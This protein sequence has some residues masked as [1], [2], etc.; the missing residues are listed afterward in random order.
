V[1][2]QLPDDVPALDELLSDRRLLAPIVTHR[3]RGAEPTRRAMRVTIAEAKARVRDRSR[4]MG[5]RLREIGRTIRRRSR[6][7]NRRDSGPFR[8]SWEVV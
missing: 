6:E 7:A 1:V 5:R 3:Q 2:R 8:V 4:A